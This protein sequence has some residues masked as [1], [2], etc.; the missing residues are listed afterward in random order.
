MGK[1]VHMLRA[2][3]Q[4]NLVPS[5]GLASQA[6]LTI[7]ESTRRS[8]RILLWILVVLFSTAPWLAAASRS[9]YLPYDSLILD[10]SQGRGIALD[11]AHQQIFT[12][13]ASLDRV[14]VLSSAD[15]HLIHSITVLS[16]AALDIS[17]DGSTLAV[18]TTGNHILFF[19][20]AD[21]TRINDIIWPGAGMGVTAFF[22]TSNGNA[23]V[24]GSSI[25][26]TGG[27][28]TAYWDHVA[29]SFSFYAT[30]TNT[31]FN[32]S[33]GMARSGDYTK[34][35]L[36]D[37]TT[38]GY[39]QIIDGTTGEVAWST[40]WV[41]FG[42]FV[43]F[44]AINKDASRYAICA[45]ELIILDSAFD[46]IYQD[47]QGCLGMTFSGDGQTLYR[48]VTPNSGPYTQALDMASFTARN[49]PNFFTSAPA[50]SYATRWQAA[51]STGM[52]YGMSLNNSAGSAF[53]ALDTTSSIAPKTPAISDP[54]HIVHVID[55]IGSPQ[56]GDLIRLLCTGVDTASAT[57]VSVTIGGVP[58][59][60]LTINGVVGAQFIP[61][62]RIVIVKTPPGSPGLADVV[63]TVNGTSDTAKGA[64]QYANSRTI[65]PLAPSPN[66]LL[67]DALRN[68]L[69][70]ATNNQVQVIDVASK[71][72]L[73]PLSTSGQTANSRFAG[74]SLSPDGNRLYIADAGA[75][76]IHMLDLTSPGSGFSIDAGKAI[77]SSNPVSPSRV[78]ELSTGKLLG[79]GGTQTGTGSGTPGLF[80]ID[81]TTQTGGR[82]HDAFGNPIQA[83]AWNSTNAG[84]NVLISADG[85]GLLLSFVGVY[86]ADSSTNVAPQNT[87]LWSD[88]IEEASA[89][90]D[91]TV[92]AA[93]GST[94]G[95]QVSYPQF[96]DFDQYALG[97]LYNHFDVSMPVGTPSFFFHPT[98]A[99]FY[100]AGSSDVGASVEIDDVHAAQPAATVT[101]PEPFI[102][103]Y[104]PVID[105]MLTTDPTGRFLFGVTQSGI[106][107]MELNTVPLSIGNLQPGFVAPQQGQTVTIR[108]SGFASGA[109]ILIGG[110]S[111]STTYVDENTLTVTT[112]SLST[113]WPDITV[114]LPGGASYTAT[115][116][117]Q[118][119]GTQP[120]PVITGFSPTSVVVQSG[121]P[122]FDQPAQVTVQ[123]TGFESYDTVEIN[124]QTVA[125]SFI[126]SGDIS[127]T[128]PATLTGTTRSISIAVVSPYTGP[129]NTMALHMVNPVPSLEDNA[130]ITVVPGNGLNLNLY[131]RGFVSGSVIQ[132][133][134]QNLQTYLSGGMSS[135]GLEL[136]WASVPGSMTTAGTAVVTVFNPPPGG[137][138][139]NSID[140]DVSAAHP[141]PYIVVMSGPNNSNLTVNYDIPSSL[142]LGTNVTGTST[143]YTLLIQNTGTANYQFSSLSISPGAFS[144]TSNACQ[145]VAPQPSGQSCAQTV[146]FAPTSI[147]PATATLTLTDNAPGSPHAITLTGQG[148][149]TP[150]PTVTLSSI[151]SLEDMTSASLQGHVVMGG[152]TIAGVAWIEYGTDPT[153][154]N[155]TKSVSWSVLGDGLINGNLANLSAGTL[156][157]ARLVVQSQ[158]GTGTSAIHQ[159]YTVAAPA[160]VAIAL[161]SG[162]SNTAT[163]TA[164]G[165]ATYSLAA[166]NGGNGYVG[167]VSFTCT[168]A[169]SASTC[170][171]NPSQLT[172]SATGN[173]PFTV[174]VKTTAS[175]TASLARTLGSGLGFAFCLL[176][177]LL[178]PASRKRLRNLGLVLAF[179]VTS[180]TLMSCS[181][182]G[183]GGSGGGGGGGTPGTPAGTYTLTITGTTNGAQ[184]VYTLTL[185]VQ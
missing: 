6:V 44:L 25:S 74:L 125:S 38:G 112:P 159:F 144:G 7:Q 114:T 103:S 169:P 156:Y 71:T 171:V 66:F 148:I 80:L 120:K 129:S 163:V 9:A 172:L 128:I 18:G 11:T 158:G 88:W 100:K 83:Y 52:V 119:L 41:G 26:S 177:G 181:G 68:R 133:N 30:G 102:G 115:G 175:T 182:G 105:H 28:G 72:L 20:T 162:G 73:T 42:T 39:V 69:Y 152:P 116:L 79:S 154:A 57:H 98:G 143:T 92:I 48:D 132:W 85:D 14:D 43:N 17:P 153:L 136:V 2:F 77:G 146:T 134:G 94:P 127:A 150:V 56:G 50:G 53:V 16:P 32:D 173:T 113:G 149:A 176:L 155:F 86:S 84:H 104:T 166:S 22:F 61:N 54:T 47:G 183:G 5:V 63:L 37:N 118:V 124:G 164:G 131:G 4:G 184:S 109:Q 145:P 55:N 12:A 49:V 76:L 13:W 62:Q 15:Y 33:G 87:G 19:N 168:G 23:I 64:F 93:G 160:Q 70:A 117:L 10:G 58:A 96:L 78:F 34:V 36:G 59:T 170:A 180:L 89:D 8:V 141:A 130:P 21:F 108:G 29:N 3:V 179:V 1:W 122:G 107:I 157:S 151:N 40:G 142:D 51:D 147:G 82:A 90:E 65:I 140:V 45:G 27:G 135:N 31:P 139:S 75:N 24:R 97:V 111:T 110:S 138:V 91:G 178:S 185:V 106:T 67:F 174:S 126:H 99:L 60:N 121:I 101:F 161:G 95:I 137:G 165:T 46:E 35:I 81:P 123:G 167:T